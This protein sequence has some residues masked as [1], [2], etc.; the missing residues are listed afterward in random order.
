MPS[1]A[2]LGQRRSGRFAVRVIMEIASTAHACVRGRGGRT[3][4]PSTIEVDVD[5]A[6]AAAEPPEGVVGAVRPGDR[7]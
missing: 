1:M 6:A 3:R 5:G 2:D 7:R 4:W